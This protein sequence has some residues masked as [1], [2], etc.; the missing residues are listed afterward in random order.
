MELSNGIWIS[1]PN[2]FIF[3]NRTDLKS[4]PNSFASNS[5]FISGQMPF[6][7]KWKNI[8][9]RKLLY[10]V[11]VII[12]NSRK[13]INFPIGSSQARK[14]IFPAKF[15]G[16]LLRKQKIQVINSIKAKVITVSKVHL[17]LIKI[18]LNSVKKLLKQN[19]KQIYVT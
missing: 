6:L 3:W 1:M 4:N 11:E 9:T 17:F 13:D 8:S 15:M 5:I 12:K 2:T 16:K 19:A 7:K 14:N 18:K 10:N